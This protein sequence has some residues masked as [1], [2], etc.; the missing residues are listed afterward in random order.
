MNHSDADEYMVVLR[1]AVLH[2]VEHALGNL[3]QR[4]QHAARMV[5]G[6]AGVDGERLE[7]AVADL[8]RLL[9]L[10]FDYVSPM[11]IQARPTD[12]AGVAES[13]ALQVGVVSGLEIGCEA[14]PAVRVLADPGVLQRSFLLLSRAYGGSWAQGAKV[15]AA[16]VCDAAGERVRFEVEAPPGAAVVHTPQAGLAAAV[17]GRLIELQGGEL[18]VTMQPQPRCAVLL[19]VER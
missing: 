5:K 10:L 17:A 2:D 19:P 12:A 1:R 3:L 16:L 15:T 6:G 8:G 14:S 18:V 11:P 13:L 9:E 7:A 4:L